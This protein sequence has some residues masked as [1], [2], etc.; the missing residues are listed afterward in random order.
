MTIEE[1]FERFLKSP[2][3]ISKITEAE[4]AEME[5]ETNATSN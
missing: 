4:K 3:L 2:I 5:D 1:L